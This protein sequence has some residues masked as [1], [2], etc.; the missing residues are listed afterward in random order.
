MPRPKILTY[1]KEGKSVGSHKGF[2]A[3]F[4]WLVNFC[5]HL[6]GDGIG[7]RVDRRNQDF[8]CIRF[9]GEAGSSAEGGYSTP[10]DGK[11]Y[12]PTGMEIDSDNMLLI[13]KGRRCIWKD[14]RLD[15]VSDESDTISAL[16]LV[17]HKEVSA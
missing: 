3:T 1:L 6:S 9:I 12:I 16:S 14:G 10:D 8:P 15:Y 4:N 2:A 11:D 7:I 13:L 5:A 17:A